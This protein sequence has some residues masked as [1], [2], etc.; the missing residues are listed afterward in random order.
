[1]SLV[2]TLNPDNNDSFV[3]LPNLSMSLPFSLKDPVPSSNSLALIGYPQ[4]S[5]THPKQ[6]R[7]EVR[8]GY[9]NINKPTYIISLPFELREEIYTYLVFASSFEVLRVCRSINM[10][11]TPLL[12][13]YG[14]YHIRAIHPPPQYPVSIPPSTTL[15]KVQ[16]LYI[17]M[18]DIRIAEGFPWKHV[19]SAQ[20]K[21][22][23]RHFGGD[24]VYRK[25]CHLDLQAWDLTEQMVSL[26]RTFVG[27]E[28][29]R[30]TVRLRSY[31]IEDDEG[32]SLSYTLNM[33]EQREDYIKEMDE[34]L[35]SYLGPAGCTSID[36]P[37]TADSWGVSESLLSLE[38]RPRALLS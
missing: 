32:D 16:N 9:R 24:D 17:S 15:A 22:L 23:L 2:Q 10:Q 35:G 27:F 5:A 31:D 13:K 12:Y 37:D 33:K 11:A 8:T 36:D 34:R 20:T 7:Y 26:L 30:I 3:S 29:I 6:R 21:S 28:R 14:V 19:M 25:V 1:M 38:F 18:P 4:F